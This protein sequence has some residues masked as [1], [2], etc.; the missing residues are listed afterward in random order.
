MSSATESLG[1][2]VYLFFLIVAVSSSGYK[3]DGLERGAGADRDGR[4]V[5]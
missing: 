5:L 1:L 4:L 2:L 3:Q